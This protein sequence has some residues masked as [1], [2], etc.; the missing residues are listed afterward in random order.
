[1]LN[2]NATETYEKLK[3]RYGEHA[4]SRTRV[5]RWHKT[6]L[7]GREGVEDQL[8][9]GRTCTSKTDGNVTKLRD[10]VSSDHRTGHAENLCQAGP[11]NSHQ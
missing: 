11:K 10:L 1:M 4:V 7:D 6:F 8:R 3:R 5:F 9:S 2:E